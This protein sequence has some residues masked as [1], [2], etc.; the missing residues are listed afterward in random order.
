MSSDD[1]KLSLEDEMERAQGLERDLIT[2]ILQS[3]RRAWT[4]ALS[5]GVLTIASV[6]AVA[7]LMPMKEPPELYIVRVDN[8]SGMIEHVSQLG[9]AQDDYGERLARFFI[10]QYVLACESYDW[11]TIQQSY[12]RCALFSSP[13]VQRAYYERFKGEK[14]LDKV[15]GQHSR[16]RV[17]VRSITLGPNQSATVRFS[18]S[19]ENSMGKASPVENLLATLGYGYINANLSEAVGRENPL[20][21]QVLS[22]DTD[23]EVVGR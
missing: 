6:V 7:S 10:N 9:N 23:V 4:V 12:N 8:A 14:A 16:V 15:Y 1:P 3:R 22:Y 19:I 2:E 20:G 21:F 17:D 5:A 13:D 18:R 11:Y